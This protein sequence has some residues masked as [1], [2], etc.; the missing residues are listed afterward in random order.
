[1]KLVIL[2]YNDGLLIYMLFG[3]FSVNFP[4]VFTVDTIIMLH[5][6]PIVKLYLHPHENQNP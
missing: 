4:V 1:M 3:G 2:L 5:F 6:E